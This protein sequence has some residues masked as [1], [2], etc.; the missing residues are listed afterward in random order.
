M[1]L[2]HTAGFAYAFLDRRVSMQTRPVG[3]EEFQGDVQDILTSP[4]VNQP[5]TMWEYGVSL[6]S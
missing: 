6:V 5:G 2:A 4:M 3:V 1:L